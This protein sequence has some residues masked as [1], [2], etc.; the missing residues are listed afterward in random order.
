MRQ[1]IADCT[2]LIFAGGDSRRMGRDKTRI[3]LDGTSLLQGA[4]D[5]MRT[6]FPHVLVSLRHRRSDIEARQVLDAVPAA[7]PLAGLC[8]GLA[9]AQTPWVFAIA[10]DMP[11]VATDL[12]RQLAAWRG[13]QQAVVP[14]ID[15]VAQTLFAFYAR[16]AL[17]TIES[18]L[19]GTG[20]RGLAAALAGLDVRW[21]EEAA[22]RSSDPQLRSFIDLDTPD[23]LARWRAQG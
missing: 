5:R 10:A 22:L 4:I 17:P 6:V 12:I 1:L 13:A 3:E 9:A 8:A 15:G 16:T 18:T 11:F 20:K 23:D 21:V 19:A 14:R 2:A 7:G